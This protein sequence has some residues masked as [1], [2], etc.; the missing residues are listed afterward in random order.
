MNA[1]KAGRCSMIGLR[2]DEIEWVRMLVTL[3][4]H[5]DPLA[6]ELARQALEYVH[7]VVSGS[8]RE[9]RMNG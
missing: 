6:P 3:L 7:T 5:P 4:R 2:P 1:T 9:Q 8:V